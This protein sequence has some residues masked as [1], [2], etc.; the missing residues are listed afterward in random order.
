MLATSRR[1]EILRSAMIADQVS[2]SGST[3]FPLQVIGEG[4]V[5]R[6]AE[7][8]RFQT[9]LTLD[10]CDWAPSL[11]SVT[12]L[13]PGVA[14]TVFIRGVRSLQVGEVIGFAR[15]APRVVTISLPEV[16]ASVR[17]S[18]QLVL[19]VSSPALTE[20][21]ISTKPWPCAEHCNLEAPRLAYQDFADQLGKDLE[22]K[23]ARFFLE[24]DAATN[25]YL[26]ERAPKSVTQQDAREVLPL[27]L[28]DQAV[29]SALIEKAA[30]ILI[31]RTQLRGRVAAKVAVEGLP[32][33]GGSAIPAPADLKRI[34]FTQEH[35]GVDQPLSVPEVRFLSALQME[36]IT[37][38]FPGTT[39]E[40]ADFDAV[41]DAFRQFASGNL[42]RKRSEPVKQAAP[43]IDSR[44]SKWN[45]EPDSA[46][47]FLFAEFALLALE[48]LEAAGDADA[49]KFWTLM[50]P[51][52]EEVQTIYARC[53]APAKPRKPGKPGFEDYRERDVLMP[54][55]LAAAKNPAR[56]ASSLKPAS[57]EALAEKIGQNILAAFPG[58]FELPGA[59]ADSAA[60]AYL[61]RKSL[62]PSTAS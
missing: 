48:T 27:S 60:T 31:R 21:S 5:C 42:R 26:F 62:K 1:I 19:E 6:R 39:G 4:L 40:L 20:A 38:H 50:L 10:L 43:R 25:P 30:G 57:P 7:L 13:F 53:Y 59:T 9:K 12:V 51:I 15:P 37:R 29:R 11:K 47:L 45:G 46:K 8:D 49:Q 55:K 56:S 44:L 54:G 3:E 34:R 28:F 17:P 32:A 22:N 2:P 18:L 33:A 35:A 52:F 61:S 24:F 14:K 16:S 36:M 41:A 58:D 23:A